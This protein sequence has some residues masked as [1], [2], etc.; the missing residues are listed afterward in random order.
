[1]T[2]LSFSPFVSLPLFSFVVGV[3]TLLFLYLEITRKTAYLPLRLVAVIIMMATVLLLALRPSYRSALTSSGYLLL[4]DNYSKKKVDSLLKVD[5]SLQCIHLEK[6]KPHPTSRLLKPYELAEINSSIRFI[7]GDGVPL[8]MLDFLTN[9]NIGYLPGE[10]TMG[11]QALHIPNP[12]TVNEKNLIQGTFTTN[13]TGQL[14]L[15][16]PGGVED[17]VTVTNNKSSFSLAFKPLNAGKFLYTLEWNA[18]DQSV[19]GKLPLE[20][21]PARK[22]NTLFLQAAP[23]IEI[24]MLK[25]YLAEGGHG[26]SARYQLSKEKYRYEYVNSPNANLSSLTPE[27]LKKF[28]LV[29][30]ENT[31]LS[32]LTSREQKSLEQAV[33]EGL[34][35]LILL[36]SIPEKQDVLYRFM[37]VTKRST[38]EDTLSLAL[39]DQ[40]KFKLK[41]GPVLPADQPYLVSHLVKGSAILAGHVSLGFGKV[42]FQTLDE[43]YRL[44]LE[45]E[46]EAYAAC[47][48]P[49]LKNTSRKSKS[50]T[51]L[52][53]KNEFPVYPN[54]AIHFSIFQENTPSLRSGKIVIP[55][56]E[57]VYIDNIWSGQTWADSIGWQSIENVSDSTSLNYY[58]SDPEEWR[59]LRIQKQKQE[60]LNRVA[61][62]EVISR[63]HQAEQKEVSSWIFFLTFLLSAAFLWLAPKL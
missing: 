10:E 5:P 54:D 60:L 26:I 16:G 47:W 32:T 61:N 43:T 31:T 33:K 50:S 34:G 28:D 55:V 51:Q 36:N 19:Q 13:T 4:T 57:D 12:I 2:D 8:P 46:K 7:L 41:M 18:K 3:L 44:S 23:G 17:S 49:L 29:I 25:S 20:V 58:V 53:L 14:R 11:V 37:N 45:G 22:L 52:R 38:E 30:L 62:Q 56:Q 9:P 6:V 40:K 35:L 1:M 15:L 39:I 59:S 42:G 48:T 63:Q 24:R 21:L 27:Q